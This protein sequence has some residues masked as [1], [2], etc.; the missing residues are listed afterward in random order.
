M[1]GKFQFV[2]RF[3]KLKKISK[4]PYID[5]KFMRNEKFEIAV[6]K[7]EIFPK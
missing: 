3:S 7:D 5:A 6:Y 1:G 4:W 2:A